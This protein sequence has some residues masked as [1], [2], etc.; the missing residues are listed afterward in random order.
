MVAGFQKNAL[1]ASQPR[2]STRRW[3]PCTAQRGKVIR[4]RF[5]GHRKS[6]VWSSWCVCSTFLPRSMRMTSRSSLRSEVANTSSG[7]AVQRGSD[8]RKQSVCSAPAQNTAKHLPNTLCQTALFQKQ[9]LHDAV[10][11]GHEVATFVNGKESSRGRGGVMQG[12]PSS[13]QVGCRVRSSISFWNVPL[14]FRAP[15][16][17]K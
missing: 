2:N 12:T 9:A 8:A 6:A 17:I 10:N 4:N 14:A 3:L 15:Q 16:R 5:Y 7:A 13:P 11:D 1:A